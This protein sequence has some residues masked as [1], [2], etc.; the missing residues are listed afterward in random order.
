MSGATRRDRALV[1]V[2]YD[3]ASLR[4]ALLDCWGNSTRSHSLCSAEVPVASD[5]IDLAECLILD[6]AM[7]VG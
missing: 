1:S 5:Q 6:V 3:D 7:P 2:V 4:E